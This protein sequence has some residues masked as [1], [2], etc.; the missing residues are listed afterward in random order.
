MREQR[1]TGI[2]QQTATKCQTLG[3]GGPHRWRNTTHTGIGLFA[4]LSHEYFGTF[5]YKRRSEKTNKKGTEKTI[6][7][8]ISYIGTL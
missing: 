7:C 2:S 3:I 6:L 8:I 4:S 5:L 1:E